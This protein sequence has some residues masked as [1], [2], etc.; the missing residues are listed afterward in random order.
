MLPILAPWAYDIIGV[1]L[2]RFIP[3]MKLRGIQLE[4][5]RKKAEKI[6]SL[7]DKQTLL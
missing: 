1:I 7:H 6:T 3:L 2:L 4:A 5:V